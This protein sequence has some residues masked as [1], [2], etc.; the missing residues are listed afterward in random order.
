M[1][2]TAL[3]TPQNSFD[4]E[5]FQKEVRKM[6]KGP[7]WHYVRPLVKAME[8]AENPKD[9]VEYI[10]DKFGDFMKR[11]YI[12]E[13]MRRTY[14]DKYTSP[15]ARDWISNWAFGEGWELVVDKKTGHVGWQLKRESKRVEESKMYLRSS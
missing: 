11:Q 3:T 5:E 6:E 15:R 13:P 2:T 14:E 8:R 1:L 10:M 9:Y 4:F 12:F 7:I